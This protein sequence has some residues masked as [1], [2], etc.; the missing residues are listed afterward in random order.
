MEAV[1]LATYNTSENQELQQ[2]MSG[3]GFTPKRIKEGKA[4]L[5]QVRLLDTTQQQHYLGARQVSQQIEQDT[6]TVLELFKEHAA[7]ARTAFRKEPLV[8]EELKIK[9]LPYKRWERI[10]RAMN[11]YT[12]A[13][14]YLPQLQQ[15]GATPESLQQNKA[16]AEALL[17]LKA[18]R[19]RKK[20]EAENSTQVKQQAIK[21]LKAWYSEFRRLA[22]IAFQ[23]TPQILETYGIV[24][25][26]S[27]KKRS[28]AAD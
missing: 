25:R 21:A 18:Q 11:F 17:A 24:V 26:S 1:Q 6:A 2:K 8:L 14:P 3:Y 16:G 10:Q 28:V 13:T 7:I 12:N 20:G 15:Y 9:K 4:L 23:E 22:R 19:L 27:P 5:E